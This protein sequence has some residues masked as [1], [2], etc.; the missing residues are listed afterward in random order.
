MGW[1]GG[2]PLGSAACRKP[3]Y[4]PQWSATLPSLRATLWHRPHLLLFLCPQVAGDADSLSEDKQAE[5]EEEEEGRAPNSPGNPG[6]TH[7]VA[8][9]LASLSG[10]Q[11]C[12]ASGEDPPKPAGPA[13][14]QPPDA[15]C[16]EGESRGKPGQQDGVK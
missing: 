2:A 3:R 5:S 14:C 8:W 11:H 7:T 13:L 16:A 10:P 4:S 9:S 15:A 1:W 12:S 6:G